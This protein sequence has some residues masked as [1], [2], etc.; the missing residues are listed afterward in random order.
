M[1]VELLTI[2]KVTD[3]KGQTVSIGDEVSMVIDG[4]PVTAIYK[5]IGTRG[6]LEFQGVGAY[7]KFAF[8]KMPKSIQKFEKVT[9]DE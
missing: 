5:G 9:L 2:R 3:D 7:D 1:R 8:A 4:L 6:A